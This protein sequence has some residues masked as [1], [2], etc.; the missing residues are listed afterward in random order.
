MV[1]IRPH[2][3]DFV[4]GPAEI[5]RMQRQIAM[6]AQAGAD[7]VVLGLLQGR[8][9]RVDDVAL[10]ALLAESRSRSLKVTFHRAFDATPDPYAAL[11][12]LIAL[13]V[14]RIL[15]SGS[16]WG[17]GEGALAGLP[18]LQRLVD[19]A[20]GRIEIVIG[21]GVTLANAKSIGA[22]LPPGARIAFHAYSSVLRHARVSAAAVRM[23][24]CAR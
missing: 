7:G 22:A 6:A 19:Q 14:D 10:A 13:G 5:A 3:G 17:S 18:T 21:G 16:P 8:D 9:G 12:T 24:Q 23:L 1:M 20:A 2:A 15:T 4:Y 11:E